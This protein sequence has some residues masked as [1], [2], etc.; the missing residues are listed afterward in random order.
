MALS[1]SLGRIRGFGSIENH[2]VGVLW[3][4]EILL[5]EVRTMKFTVVDNTSYDAPD[6]EDIRQSEFRNCT[7]RAD[8]LPEGKW[9]MIDFGKKDLIGP[10]QLQGHTSAKGYQVRWSGKTA[11]IRRRPKPQDCSL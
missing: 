1:A 7:S 10:A 11:W 5:G 2:R 3:Q 6:F 9:L 8:A 4:R